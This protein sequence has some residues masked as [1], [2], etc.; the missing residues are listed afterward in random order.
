MKIAFIIA[1]KKMFMCFSCL[2]VNTLQLSLLG[3]YDNKTV[4]IKMCNTSVSKYI[5]FFLKWVRRK[6][7]ASISLEQAD[8]KKCNVCNRGAGEAANRAPGSMNEMRRCTHNCFMG[9]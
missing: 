7:L 2:G 3:K 4:S 8:L 6:I 9:V 5:N 1:K